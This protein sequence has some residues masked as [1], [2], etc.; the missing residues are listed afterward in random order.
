LNSFDQWHIR[1]NLLKK[2][3]K[4]KQKK[5]VHFLMIGTLLWTSTHIVR[6][7]GPRSIPSQVERNLIILLHGFYMV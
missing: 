7:G 4:K 2:G 3:Q 5:T 6:Q 1:D